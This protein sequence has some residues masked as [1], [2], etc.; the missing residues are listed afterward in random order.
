[1]SYKDTYQYK[2]MSI[3]PICYIFL[4]CDVATMH[5]VTQVLYEQLSE[6]KLLLPTIVSVVTMITEVAYS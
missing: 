6:V 4:F 1:M 2:H 5:V 3:L